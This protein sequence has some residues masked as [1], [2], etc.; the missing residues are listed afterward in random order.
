MKLIIK[1]YLSLLKESKELDSLIPELLLAMGHEVISKPQIGV[2][3]YGV[4]VASVA[5]DSDGVEKVF[6][7]TIKEGDF[8]RADWD[9]GLQAVRPSLNEIIDS[10]IPKKLSSD[11]QKLVKKIVLAT[12]GD[13]K[14]EIDDNWNGYIEKNSIENK[15]EFE[16]WGGDKL[17]LFVEEYIFNEY[18][19]PAEQRSLFRKT[20]AL[21]GDIDYDL[22]DYYQFLNEILFNNKLETLNDKKIL[23]S[24]RLIFLSLNI[25]DFWA[26]NE[27]NLKKSLYASEKTLLNV[28]QFLNKNNLQKKKHLK[29]MF[30]KLYKKHLDIQKKYFKKIYLAIEV[31][32]GLSL[33]GHD[34]LQESIVLFEQLGIMSLYGNFYY[35]S[36]FN[37]SDNSLD[38]IEYKNIKDAIKLMI[39]NNKGLLNPVY[40]EHIIDIS[41]ALHLLELWNETKFIDKWMYDLLSHIDFA[42]QRGSYFPINTNNFEDLVELNI[43][44]TKEKNEYITT[45]ILLPTLAFWCVK[46]GLLENYKYIVHLSK[47]MYKESTLQVWFPDKDTKQFIYIEKASVESGYVFAPIQ[48]KENISEFAEM[49][50]LLVNKNYLIDLDNNNFPIFYLVSSRHFRV[51]LFPHFFVKEVI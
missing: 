33:Y 29:E 49:I 7:F 45:S 11:T 16:F 31:K 9:N 41:L 42:Y 26:E 43:G 36:F 37:K 23:K 38:Y 25:I 20:L 19:I 35:A 22:S 18:I 39:E 27:D 34:F 1:E 40:E 32:Q 3:Q 50:E 28:Y 24:L 14:Q 6:L 44:E 48:I 10:Y 17:A 4:D 21:I 13:K 2:R 5:K 15:I 12:G 51:P 47:E 8:G 46:L 30:N